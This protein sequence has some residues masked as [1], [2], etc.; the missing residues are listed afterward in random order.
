MVLLPYEKQQQKV[1]TVEQQ[2][3]PHPRSEGYAD[4]VLKV[5]KLSRSA[6][7]IPQKYSTKYNLVCC[8]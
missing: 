1:A 7:K 5:E 4:Y 8:L 3:S 6:A 2:N